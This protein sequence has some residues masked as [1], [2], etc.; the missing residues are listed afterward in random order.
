MKLIFF[1][2]FINHHAIC[3]F[4]NQSLGIT[5]HRWSTAERVADYNMST[6]RW[7]IYLFIRSFFLSFGFVSTFRWLFD[8]WI[9]AARDINRCARK[10]FACRLETLDFTKQHNIIQ[11]AR[12]QRIL[13]YLFPRAFD[14]SVQMPE[15]SKRPRPVLKTGV[16][17]RLR[18]IVSRT[19]VVTVVQINGW[20]IT[21]CGCIADTNP[22]DG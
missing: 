16:C 11:T 1:R 17:T 20:L 6:L 8:K 9:Y 3:D 4:S 12:A 18:P 21:R 10:R 19:N 14:P 22:D 2:E 13:L 15:M 5:R 7:L